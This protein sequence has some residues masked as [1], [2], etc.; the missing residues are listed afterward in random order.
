MKE[1]MIRD[2][3]LA[4]EGIRKINWVRKNMPILKILREDFEKNQ[5]FKGIRIAV[6]VHL[7]AK[8]A[9]L[10]LLLAEGGAEVSVT[11]SNPLSTKDDVVAALDKLGLHVYAW[12]G[13]TRDEYLSHINAALDIKPQIVIDDG[14]DLVDLIH[15]ERSELLQEVMGACE[16]T[17]TGVLRNKARENAG[18]LKF[19]VLAVN[20]AWCKYLFDNRYGT[21]QSTLDALMRTTNLIVT[22]KEVV[23]LGYG[24][25]GKGVASRMKGAG[26]RVIV[27]EVDPVKALEAVMDGFRVMPMSDA[28]AEGDFFITTTGNTGV[29]SGEH[30][31]RMKDGAIIGNAGHF[32]VEID[33]EALSD[34]SVH[35]EEVR[36]NLFGYLLPDGRWI[37]I[38]GDG[39]IV[40]ITCADGH[41]AEIM[42]MSFALQALS[43]KYVLDN[44]GSLPV[45]VKKVPDEIDMNVALLK[46]KSLGISID[47]LTEEQKEYL[48]GFRM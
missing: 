31:D 46:L 37:N 17:T 4:D 26:A 7:E 33:L 9:V 15:E 8:T 12:H 13:S 25:V 10:A 23:V 36:E 6:S 32:P 5:Y 29:I 16:E 42:D 14:G 1:N 48:N 45:K 41:P 11:G 34:M 30:F 19:P 35:K 43:A 24:W 3:S 27:T 22:G 39:N 21:G 40:N 2:A 20:D 44:Q 47:T 38:L 28:A 18:E